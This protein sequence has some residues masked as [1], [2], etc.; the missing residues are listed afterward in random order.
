MDFLSNEKEY[1]LKDIFGKKIMSIVAG[2]ILLIISIV[3]I[4]MMPKEYSLGVCGIILSL[5]YTALTFFRYH[6]INEENIE[7][8]KA[9]C[10]DKNRSGYR[11]QYYEYDFVIDDDSENTFTIK[12]S[13]KTKFHKNSKYVLCFKKTDS[14]DKYNIS[15]LLSFHQFSGE[16]EK[17][18]NNPIKNKSGEMYLDTATTT[19]II[20]VIGALILGLFLL[21]VNGP[22]NDFLIQAFNKQNT[23]TISESVQFNDVIIQ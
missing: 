2:I 14:L 18:T 10:Y 3:A 13:Q 1:F 19:I 17:E 15:T 23:P 22:F 16:V 8:V 5:M 12:T 6:G 4:F 20:V 21:L 7:I 11:K 9:I